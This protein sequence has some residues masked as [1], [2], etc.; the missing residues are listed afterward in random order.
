VDL[1]V[2]A[3]ACVGRDICS[4]GVWDPD[5]P[6]WAPQQHGYADRRLNG[7]DFSY[8]DSPSGGRFARLACPYPTC[9]TGL[10]AAPAVQ[11]AG[12]YVHDPG[13]ADPQRANIDG[14]K[15]PTGVSGAAFVL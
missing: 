9:K 15:S 12:F 11:R 1:G 2:V 13:V 14:I 6:G 5:L 3:V 4:Q 7:A 8:A 10:P